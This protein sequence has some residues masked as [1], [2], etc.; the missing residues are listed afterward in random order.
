MAD[1]VIDD[2]KAQEWLQGHVERAGGASAFAQRVGVSLP[3]VS[4]MTNGKKPITGKVAKAIG[5][6]R[7]NYY[8]LTKVVASPEQERYENSRAAW[9]EHHPIITAEELEA[10]REAAEA[11][12]ACTDQGL[13]QKPA[14]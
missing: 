5:L 11:Q 12:A 6:K 4:A 10:R 14:K 1:L 2:K 13:L 3:C 9:R 8:E 7:V